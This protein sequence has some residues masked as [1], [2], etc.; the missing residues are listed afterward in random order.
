MSVESH[1]PQ[2]RLLTQKGKHVWDHLGIKAKFAIEMPRA[3]VFVGVTL[4]AR[5][6][7]QHDSGL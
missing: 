4:N 7:P 1:T 5:S 3:D 6:Q 2:G